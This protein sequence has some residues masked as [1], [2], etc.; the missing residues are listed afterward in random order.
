MASAEIIARIRDQAR[1]QL[2]RPRRRTSS[3]YRATVHTALMHEHNFRPDCCGTAR[4]GRVQKVWMCTKPS[5]NLPSNSIKYG[6]DNQIQ[7]S[8]CGEMR[9]R[10]SAR[11]ARNDDDAFLI[12]FPAYVPT[13]SF[14]SK[15]GRIH[16]RLHYLLSSRRFHLHAT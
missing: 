16:F 8:V 1:Q 6:A 12:G 7:L 5:S 14:V 9:G 15:P 2:R 4:E 10:R 11:N 13:I 3:F